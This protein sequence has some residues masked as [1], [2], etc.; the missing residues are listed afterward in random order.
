M[1]VTQPHVCLA[2]AGGAGVPLDLALLH[3]AVCLVGDVPLQVRVH[4]LE[5]KK[6]LIGN[7][8]P[9]T[10]VHLGKQWTSCGINAEMVFIHIRF[11]LKLQMLTNSAVS[12]SLRTVEDCT[13][14]SS[15]VLLHRIIFLDN[16]LTC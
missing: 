3:P 10:G 2:P 14:L 16:R 9:L 7:G 12:I 6:D 8:S 1:V 4:A 11:S 15:A 5:A 13:S